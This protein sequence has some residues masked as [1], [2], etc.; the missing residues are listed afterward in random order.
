MKLR[1]R[2]RA[3]SLTMAA[4]N[5]CVAGFLFYLSRL[6]ASSALDGLAV[7]S[8]LVAVLGSLL[9]LLFVVVTIGWLVDSVRPSDLGDVLPR[10]RPGALA[11]KDAPKGSPGPQEKPAR[12]AGRLIGRR[13][14]RA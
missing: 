8:V 2:T 6:A 4:L 3:Y 1:E 14:D 9:T 11:R 10:I 7:V 5:L 12:D 13:G